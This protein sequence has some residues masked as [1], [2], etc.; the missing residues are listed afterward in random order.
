MKQHQ[1]LR[2][3]ERALLDLDP[4]YVHEFFNSD[5]G[6]AYLGINKPDFLKSGFVYVDGVYF[7]PANVT[8]FKIIASGLT[9]ISYVGGTFQEVDAST[10]RILSRIVK[11]NRIVAGGF[12]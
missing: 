9:R 11:T 10:E 5:V 3:V 7:N 1:K 8:Q 4:K 12:K 2:E 6:F